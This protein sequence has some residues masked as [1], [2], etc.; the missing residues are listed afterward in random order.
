[1][2]KYK[3]DL[4]KAHAKEKNALKGEFDSVLG[5]VRKARRELN[6]RKLSIALL[7]ELADDNTYIASRRLLD[8]E[9]GQKQL[10]DRE[11]THFDKKNISVE[12]I[13][14]DFTRGH[15]NFLVP[16]ASLDQIASKSI[17]TPR[18]SNFHSFVEQTEKEFLECDALKSE[19][20]KLLDILNKVN[21]DIEEQKSSTM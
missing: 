14:N 2:E 5:E 11:R 15:S 21:G 9:F 7:H 8:S 3:S 17:T 16:L 1:M 19:N 13:L 4:L 12:E 6:K 20:N 10:N 18:V